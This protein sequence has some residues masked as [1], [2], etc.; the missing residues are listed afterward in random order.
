MAGIGFDD[1]T[2]MLSLA[3]DNLK[4]EQAMLNKDIYKA[5]AYGDVPLDLFRSKEQ[6]RDPNAQMNVQLN[7]DNARLGILQVISPMVEWGVGETQ[8]QVKLAGTLEEPLVYG[9]VKIP[10][11]SL[12]F[13]HV[14][15][16]IEIFIQI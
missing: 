1:F 6:R 15:T 7:L 12:K 2:A 8:G 9:A 10:D 11:G 3:N 4:I 5:S 13:K 14:Q 16:V